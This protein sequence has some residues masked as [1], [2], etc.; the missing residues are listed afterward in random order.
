MLTEAWNKFIVTCFK[1]YKLA[2]FF[3]GI[4]FALVFG[5]LNLK[6]NK[7]LFNLGLSELYREVFL[8]CQY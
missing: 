6:Q 5:D 2:Q 4:H 7:L 1:N 8:N 3:L